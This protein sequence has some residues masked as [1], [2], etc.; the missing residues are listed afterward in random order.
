MELVAAEVD[1]LQFGVADR[2]L[3]GGNARNL[4]P[5]TASF[6]THHGSTTTTSHFCN[7]IYLR[8][9]SDSFVLQ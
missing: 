9:L 8:Y 4:S 5:I 7:L 6:A 3:V 1:G 2:D